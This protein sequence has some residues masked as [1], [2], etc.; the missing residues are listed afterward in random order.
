MVVVAVAAV[1]PVATRSKGKFAKERDGSMGR[2]K[3]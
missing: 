2:I 1:G 3:A